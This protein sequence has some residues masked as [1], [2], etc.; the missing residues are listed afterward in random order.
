MNTVSFT[1]KRKAF[2]GEYKSFWKRR[3]TFFILVNSDV[4]YST[5]TGLSTK[6]HHK[7]KART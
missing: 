2:P 3:K 1:L 5:L 4:K 6:Y 7:I